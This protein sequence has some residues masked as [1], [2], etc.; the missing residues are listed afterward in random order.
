MRKRL[1]TFKPVFLGRPLKHTGKFAA[2]LEDWRG[3]SEYLHY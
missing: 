3:Y 1:F 2:E